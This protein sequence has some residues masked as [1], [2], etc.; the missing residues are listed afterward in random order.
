ML[1][2]VMHYMYVYSFVAD[3][4]QYLACLG[5]IALVA[6]GIAR[7]AERLHLAFVQP[8]AGTIIIVTLGVLT[9]RQCETYADPETLWRTTLRINPQSWA[10]EGSLGTLAFDAGLFEEAITHYKKGLRLN[11]A[12]SQ[13]HYNLGR[14]YFQMGRLND[15]IGEYREE[16]K[17]APDNI[18]AHANLGYSLMETGRRTEAIAEF[19]RALAINPNF[20]AA[21]DNLGEALLKNGDLEGAI[22]HLERAVELEPRFVGEQ[23][24]LGIA[25]A[26]K[27]Q[28]AQAIGHF[29]KGLELNPNDLNDLANFAWLLSTCPEPSLRDG[30]KAL[31]VAQRALDLSGPA[32]PA[33]LQSLAAA[34]AE[35]GDF[36]SAAATARTALSFSVK[37]NNTQLSGV[38]RKE[39]DL[40]QR[41]KPERDFNSRWVW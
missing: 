38:L 5:I 2:F 17:I 29:E 26:K 12:F 19:Q 8:L 15:S 37:Q 3:H 11:P 41:G 20:A 4:F 36:K 18:D 22:K 32:S 10:A 1:G 30:S 16:I 23:D 24:C 14:T 28:F 31:T 35:T 27:G 39:I 40:Y 33:V 13:L 25:F 7:A 34:Q 9:W 6:A 21:H